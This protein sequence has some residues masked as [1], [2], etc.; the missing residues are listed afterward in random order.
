MIGIKRTDDV[1]VSENQ[2]YVFFKDIQQGEKV[3][4][5]QQ[6]AFVK[7]QS[8]WENFVSDFKQQCRQFCSGID[9]EFEPILQEILKTQDF[10]FPK[11][12]DIFSVSVEAAPRAEKWFRFKVN[13][14]NRSLLSTKL[15]ILMQADWGRNFIS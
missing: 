2:E 14:Q 5:E 1:L 9:S 10:S 8:T 6:E 4:R 12:G 11:W 13:L 15:W 3:A 7:F